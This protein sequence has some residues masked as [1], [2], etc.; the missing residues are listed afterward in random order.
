MTAAVLALLSA[1][2]AMLLAALVAATGAY[3]HDRRTLAKNA[4][5]VDAVAKEFQNNGGTTMRD[6]ID[7]I[8]RKID[9]EMLPRLDTGARVMAEHADRLAV[10]EARPANARTRKDDNG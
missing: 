1:P 7:R 2:D 3:L 9:V 6:A 8:E 4:T 5:K 10:L